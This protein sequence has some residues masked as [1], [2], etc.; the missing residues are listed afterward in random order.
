MK[1]ILITGASGLIGSKLTRNLQAKGH[2]VSVL[3]RNP[4]KIKNVKAYYWNVDKNEI[5]KNCLFGIDTVIHLAGENIGES[6]WTEKRKKEIIDSRT[7]SIKLL[8]E[9]IEKTNTPISTIIS[10]SAIGYY[11]NRGD[12]ILDENSSAGVGFLSDCC[13]KWETA[14]DTGHKF[15]KRIIKIRISLLLAENG[16]ALPQLKKPIHYYLSSPMGTGKQWVSWIH[17]DDLQSLFIA[18]LE[19]EAYNGIYNASSPNPVTNYELT[20]SLAKVMNRP[21]LPI[22]IPSFLLKVSMGEMS[23]LILDSTRVSSQKIKDLGFKFKY[24]DLRK[25]LFNLIKEQTK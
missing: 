24:V 13:I 11:G 5:D 14:V 17:M 20:K 16:G 4:N 3:S 12:E 19:N 18:A 15:C 9:A 22:N 25:A 1:H 6:K 7:N 10:A 23:E 2:Q 21:L 8:Y